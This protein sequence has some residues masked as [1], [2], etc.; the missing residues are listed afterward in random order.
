[1]KEEGN[2]PFYRFSHDHDSLPKV[3]Y[4]GTLVEG[5]SSDIDQMRRAAMQNG[6]G[7]T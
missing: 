1:V 6:G 5:G 7:A 4:L 2:M 3:R